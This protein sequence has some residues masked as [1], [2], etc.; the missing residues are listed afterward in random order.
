MQG[1]SFSSATAAGRITGVQP[2]RGQANATPVEPVAPVQRGSDQVEV[3]QIATYLSALRDVP[4]IRQDLVDSIRAQIAAG[5]YDTP[6]RLDAALNGL[7][8]DAA[9]DT[10]ITPDANAGKNVQDADHDGDRR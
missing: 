7:V 6:E 1:V 9:T 4:S 5:T 10:F 8:D 2:V 3:S